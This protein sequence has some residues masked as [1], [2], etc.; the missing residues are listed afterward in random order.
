MYSIRVACA[1][2]GCKPSPAHRTAVQLYNCYLVGW[3]RGAIF[4]TPRIPCKEGT[5]ADNQHQCV[6]EPNP[7]AARRNHNLQRCYIRSGI[8]I[9]ANDAWK[10]SNRI[11]SAVEKRQKCSAKLFLDRT[12]MY[13][14]I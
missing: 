6:N 5:M 7:V 10:W 1:I 12:Y 13:L 14:I 2:S 3:W 4:A 9:Y 8:C 11:K